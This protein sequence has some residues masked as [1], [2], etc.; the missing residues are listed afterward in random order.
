MRVSLNWIKD[1]IDIELSVDEISKLLTD[2]GLEVESVETYESVKGG[3][4]GLVVG[5]VIEKEKHPDADKLS[6]CKV[7]AGNEVLQIVCGAPNV[8]SGQK[9]IVALV[10]TTLYPKTGDA[11]AIKKAKIRGI[12]SFGMICAEDEI[13]IGI[14]HDGIIV[15]PSNTEIGIPASSIYDVYNDVIFEIGLT[16]NRSDAHSH[17]GVARDLLAAYNFRYKKDGILKITDYKIDNATDNK[18]NFKINVDNKEDCFKYFGVTIDNITVGESPQWLKNR[19]TAIGQKSINNIV[20]VTNY[21]LHEYGQPLHAFDLEACIGNEII[22][23]NVAANTVFKT[24][25]NQDV[26]LFATDLMICNAQNPMCIAGVYGGLDSGVK[27]TTKAIFLESAYF[28]PKSI[29]KT[30]TAHQLRTEAA[31]HFEKGIDPD[32][33]EKALHRAVELLML[34]DNQIKV[35]SHVFKI[36]HKT[37]MP[38][39]VEF[40]PNR[41]RELIGHSISNEDIYT[42]LSLLDIKIDKT[43]E[44]NKLYVPNYRV[45][46]LRDVDVIEEILRIYGF[47]NVP[48]PSKVNAA[49]NFVE[50]KDNEQIYNSVANFLSNLGYAEVMTNPLTKSKWLQQ[51][52]DNQENWVYLLSSINVELDTM[53]N[54]MLFSTLE[55]IAYNLNHKNSD[56]KIFELGKTYHKYNDKY[57]ENELL[58]NCIVGNTRQQNWKSNAIKSDFYD[59]KSI[60]DMIFQKFA[61]EYDELI[62]TTS[63]YYEYGIS[64]MKKGVELASFGKVSS[65]W[66]NFFSIKSEV[67]YAEINWLKIIDIYQKNKITYKPV[68]KYPS[69]KRDLALLINKEVRFLDLKNTAQKIS[70]QLL[71]EI[72]IFDVYTDEQMDKNQKSY[73]LSF[74][75]NDDSKTL[76][77]KDIDSIMNKLIEAY[78][79]EFNAVLR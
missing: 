11:F 8:A 56:L 14:S 6:V 54:N 59:I 10:G 37:F 46:V 42:I 22:V 51:L 62:E 13:G 76:I 72:D 50:Q 52:S 1:Y 25:D 19:L 41:V 31:V 36:E 34:I 35:T 4:D 57:A 78:S 40:N 65:K 23:K 15:L 27:S 16:P 47:N 48:I 77:D 39:E 20:D 30:S 58:V 24:L 7:N 71:K 32:F 2:I 66:T 61:I 69:V 26:K 67:Y 44:I 9:V 79:K 64:Y 60:V 43:Q 33:T 49:P 63:N 17:I 29:R 68:S 5:E 38:F 12:E 55:T 53:R 3:L 45:D 73:A 18:H 21:V 74:T 28:N 70:K 75:F